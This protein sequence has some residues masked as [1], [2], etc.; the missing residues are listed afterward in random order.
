[1]AQ[2]VEPQ[3]Q[4]RCQVCD[5]EF[6]FPTRIIMTMRVPSSFCT[7]CFNTYDFLTLRQWYKLDVLAIQVA[8]TRHQA[9]CEGR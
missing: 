5:T 4:V 1:M 6:Q 2:A 3:T 8:L 9:A 7:R